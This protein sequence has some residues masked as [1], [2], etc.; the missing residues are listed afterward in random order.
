MDRQRAQVT[1]QNRLDLGQEVLGVG[2]LE[3]LER[4]QKH[5]EDIHLSALVGVHGFGLGLEHLTLVVVPVQEQVDAGLVVGGVEHSAYKVVV[6]ERGVVEQGM[7]CG[8]KGH[9]VC[10][11][12]GGDIVP[13]CSDHALLFG[14]ERPVD[15]GR[16][17]PGEDPV[18]VVVI[19]LERELEAVGVLFVDDGGRETIRDAAV[20]DLPFFADLFGGPQVAHILVGLLRLFGRHDGAHLVV[21]G[22]AG[23]RQIVL[24]NHADFR[25]QKLGNVG[26][27][28][29]SHSFLG[30]GEA[31][32]RYSKERL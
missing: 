14:L 9:A 27:I 3:R 26:S 8:R 13:N 25:E 21:V 11:G 17:D 12:V 16:S 6:V 10:P 28:H 32:S 20:G 29:V 24:E 19:G 1:R 4:G 22:L 31:L 5:L 15:F 30:I 23:F 18:L 2:N 7:A